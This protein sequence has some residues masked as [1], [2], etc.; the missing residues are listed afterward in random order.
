MTVKRD[1]ANQ[2]ELIIADHMDTVIYDE[3]KFDT[4]ES[5]DDKDV[6]IADEVTFSDHFDTV[7]KQ[8]DGGSYEVCDTKL[9]KVADAMLADPELSIGMLSLKE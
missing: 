5:V 8:V 2:D 9:Q 6:V 4:D 3:P 1:I 7:K